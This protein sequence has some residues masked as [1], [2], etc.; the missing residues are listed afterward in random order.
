MFLL[1]TPVLLDLYG[2]RSREAEAGA[3][4]WAAR[5]PRDRLFISALTIAELEGMHFRASRKDQAMATALRGWIDTQVSPAFEGHILPVDAAVASKRGEVAIEGD[6]DALIAATAIVHGLTLVT[7]DKP[8]FKRARVR[9]IDPRSDDSE[10]AIE[11]PDWRTASRRKP[12]WLR[13]LFIRG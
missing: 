1:D 4:A 2:S 8:A 11:T 12:Q 13:G 6:R 7:F 9:P 5:T 3:A 10:G